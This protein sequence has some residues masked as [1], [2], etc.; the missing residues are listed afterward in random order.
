LKHFFVEV[1]DA[2]K[3]FFQ[4][5]QSAAEAKRRPR[6]KFHHEEEKCVIN[7]FSGGAQINLE[8]LS[9]KMS[10]LQDAATLPYSSQQVEAYVPLEKKMIHCH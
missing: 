9:S 5:R 7:L 6:S 8:W 3:I 2:A 1:V 4:T 10:Q